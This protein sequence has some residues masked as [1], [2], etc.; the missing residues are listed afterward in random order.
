MMN[1]EHEHLVGSMCFGILGVLWA[2]VLAGEWV[3]QY[4]R[5]WW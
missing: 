5:E 3:K 4:L 1:P 2:V